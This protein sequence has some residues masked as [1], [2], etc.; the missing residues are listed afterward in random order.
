[1][2]NQKKNRADAMNNN[3]IKR[4]TSLL[5]PKTSPFAIP[6]FR[7]AIIEMIIPENIAPKTPQTP[8]TSPNKNAMMQTMIVEIR[9]LEGVVSKMK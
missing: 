4:P 1:M 9:Y 7:L 6:K 5:I 8:T 3:A 2:K